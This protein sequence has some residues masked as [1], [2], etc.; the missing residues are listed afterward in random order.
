MTR[1]AALMLIAGMHAAAANIRP[2]PSLTHPATAAL[3]SPPAEATQPEARA[4][5]PLPAAHPGGTASRRK[6]PTA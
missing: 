3:V 6:G 4:D 1:L 5:R 2:A